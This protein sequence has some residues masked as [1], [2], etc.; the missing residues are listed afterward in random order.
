MSKS[1]FLPKKTKGKAQPFISKAVFFTKNPQ[2]I[3]YNYY[4]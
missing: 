2:I 1:T 3:L 4:L